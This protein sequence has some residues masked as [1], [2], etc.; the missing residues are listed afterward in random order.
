MVSETV[1]TVSRIL[2]DFVRGAKMEAKCSSVTD[3]GMVCVM[4]MGRWREKKLDR[5]KAGLD[6]SNEEDLDGKSISSTHLLETCGACWERWAA[7]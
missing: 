6:V 5:L 1:E 7:S 3:R 4:E 2:L